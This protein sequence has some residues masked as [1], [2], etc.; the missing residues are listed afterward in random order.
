MKI[1]IDEKYQV[2]II[3]LIGNLVGGENAQ[4]F[5]DNLYKLIKE[6]KKNVVVD[7]SDIKF[8]NS[9]GI[10]ILISGYT[11]LKNADGNLKLAHIS[12][13]IQGVL[14]ITKLNQVFDIYD[15]VDEAIKS[16]DLV[17]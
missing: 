7:M 11:T 17:K 12:D 14:S 1:S 9:S 5:R 16:S 10:G 8:M 4:L 2:A 15:T 3:K 6:K 13:K